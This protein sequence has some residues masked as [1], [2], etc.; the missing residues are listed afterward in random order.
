ML[1]NTAQNYQFLDDTGVFFTTLSEEYYHIFCHFGLTMREMAEIARRAIDI[2]FCD[3]SM[4]LYLQRL[5][6]ES[7]P[8]CFSLDGTE[9]TS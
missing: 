5:F 9:L 1:S 7:V 3:D 4:K 8:S 2:A 6:E